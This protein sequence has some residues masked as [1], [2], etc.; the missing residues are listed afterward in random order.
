VNKTLSALLV[1][2]GLATAV[3]PVGAHAHDPDA[4]AGFIAGAAV[5]A[6]LTGAADAHVHHHVYAHPGPVYVAPRPLAYY[7]VP[8]PRVRYVQVI[9]A[10]RAYYKPKHHHR[11]WKRDKRQW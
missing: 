1:S 11:H 4:L 8:A 10:P 6:L 5:G 3:A 2:G 7:A 9:E